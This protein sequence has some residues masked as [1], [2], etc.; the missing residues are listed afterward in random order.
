MVVN[1]RSRHSILEGRYARPQQ[2]WVTA[3]HDAPLVTPELFMQVQAQLAKH[4]NVG[5]H[6]TKQSSYALQGLLWCAR[7]SRRMYGQSK[8]G[9]GS[10]YRCPVCN[11]QRGL[12]KVESG[13]QSALAQIELN[14]DDALQ[15]AHERQ[16]AKHREILHLQREAREE[17]S[18]LTVRRHLL[19]ER[20]DR[21]VI[22]EEQY[23]SQVRALDE[24][25]D[26]W[27]QR[28]QDLTR[29]LTQLPALDGLAAR[30]AVERTDWTEW[31]RGIAARPM[32][33][34]QAIYRE[35]CAKIVLDPAENTLTVEYTPHI[36]L[37][38]GQLSCK[39]PL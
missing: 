30:L 38:V 2:D 18:R 23:R 17:V 9:K 16:E 32:E 21:G 29:E 1:F 20:L 10:H 25:R 34:Q 36:A 31:T 11:V 12:R 3:T 15:I 14:S 7:C 13:V 26:T 6:R 27:R 37:V 19:Y 33:Q 4:Q 28:E 35:C 5:Q 8:G 24:E 22:D 39:C